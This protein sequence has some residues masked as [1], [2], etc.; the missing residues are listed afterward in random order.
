MALCEMSLQREDAVLTM[1]TLCRPHRRTTPP[2]GH[3]STWRGGGE[4]DGVVIP[5]ALT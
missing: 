2:F 5:S 4:A 1:L 3:P